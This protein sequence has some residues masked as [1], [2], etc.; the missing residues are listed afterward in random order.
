MGSATPPEGNDFMAIAAGWFY[1]LAIKQVG[2]PPVEAAI[3]LTPDTLNLQ[4]KGRWISCCILLPEG[5]NA[6][7]IEPNS[8]LLEE[9]IAAD[10]VV[11]EGQAAMAKFDRSAVQEML[12]E[13]QTPAEVELLVTGELTNGT[14]FEGTDTIRVI[15]KTNK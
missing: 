13:L 14:I 12:A 8:I 6:A 1:S 10:R 2:P 4:S 11:L 3:K 5:Y 7:E 9:E 15:D